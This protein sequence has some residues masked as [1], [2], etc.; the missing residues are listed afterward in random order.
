MANSW[1]A[2]PWRTL[3]RWAA[4]E[5]PVQ[6]KP[7][8]GLRARAIGWAKSAVAFVLTLGLLGLGV[9]YR[10]ELDSRPDLDRTA[11]P[12]LMV[13]TPGR[14]LAVAAALLERRTDLAAQLEQA[15]PLVPEARMRRAGLVQDGIDAAVGAYLDQL[16]LAGTANR[17]VATGVGASPF[18]P[19]AVRRLASAVEAGTVRIDQGRLGFCGVTLTALAMMDQHL[20]ASTLTGPT[21]PPWTRAVPAAE[22]YVYTSQG[23]ALAWAELLAASFATLDASEAPEAIADVDR[24]VRALSNVASLRPRVAISFA[25]GI[26]PDRDTPALVAHR[27]ALAAQ[28]LREVSTSTWLSPPARRGTAAAACRIGTNR[29]PSA[30]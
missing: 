11:A 29:G 1:W 19:A 18:D 2:W 15:G 10:S 13:D 4:A 7:K 20:T 26:A 25:D 3:R 27:V 22:V 21:S 6:P 9:A 8:P 14:P 17:L 16:P 23:T 5:R 30:R 12:A 28:A 24:A